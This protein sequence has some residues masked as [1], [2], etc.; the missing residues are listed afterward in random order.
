MEEEEDKD[1]NDNDYNYKVLSTTSRV[2]PGRILTINTG[3]DAHADR[4]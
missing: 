1:M 3:L 2:L 4:N